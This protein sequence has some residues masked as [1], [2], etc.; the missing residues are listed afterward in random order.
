MCGGRRKISLLFSTIAL[1][2]LCTRKKGSVFFSAW[3]FL[4]WGLSARR[5]THV[6]V[7]DKESKFLV[8]N[9]GS[10]G[11]SDKCIYIYIFPR[12]DWGLTLGLGLM[13]RKIFVEG[14]FLFC[15]SDLFVL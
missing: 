11:Y 13:H 15:F 9:S 3:V 4:F 10:G 2:S 5:R 7:P 8:L 14:G 1:T 6:R 12:S